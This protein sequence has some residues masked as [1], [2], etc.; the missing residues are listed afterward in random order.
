[1][2]LLK[3]LFKSKYLYYKDNKITL[4]LNPDNYK[5]FSHL[6]VK[7]IKYYLMKHY[8]PKEFVSICNKEDTPKYIDILKIM[9]Y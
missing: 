2:E 6:D 1:M 7:I 9:N 4:N 3:N 5:S 8:N